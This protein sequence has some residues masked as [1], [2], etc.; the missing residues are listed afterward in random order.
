MLASTSS[1]ASGPED[2]WF[3]DSGALNHMMSHQEWFRE[4]RESDRLGYVETGDNTTH[5]IRH[6][7]NVPFG[8]EGNQTYIKNVLHVPT[9]TK[10]LVYVGQIVEQRMQVLF[11]QGGCVIEKRVDSSLVDEVRAK[12]SFSTHTR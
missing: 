8:K 7:R 5:L 6:N 2:V 12:C 9:T 1:S 4:L 10:N 11:N 3:V